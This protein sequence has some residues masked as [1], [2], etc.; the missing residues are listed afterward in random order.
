MKVHCAFDE[1]VKIADLKPHPRNPNKHPVDQIKRLASILEFQGFRYPIKVSKRSGLVTS[2]HGRIA[3]AKMNGWDSVPV[4]FQDY[5]SDGQ[6]WAD[7]VSDNAIAAWAELDLSAIH[8]EL[9][10]LEPFD[11]ELLGIQDFQFEPEPEKK[12][13]EQSEVKCPGCGLA[14][15]PGEI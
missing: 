1:M 9:P 4:N 8:A 3:A 14:F 2:G 10:K 13:K 11:I 6:E 12:T 15:F 7:I 5:D